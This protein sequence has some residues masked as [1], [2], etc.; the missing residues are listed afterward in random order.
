MRPNF[1]NSFSRLAATGVKSNHA[2][3]TNVTNTFD[4]AQEAEMKL[5]TLSIA[6]GAAL[7]LQ[8]LSNNA[9][10][11]ATGNIANAVP[12]TTAA[13]ARVDFSV[14]VPKFL[15][16]RV[17]STAGTIDSISFT[18]TAAQVGTNASV[19]GVGGDLGAGQVTVQAQGN[20][21][22]GAATLTYR[23]TDGAGAARAALSDGTNTMP[24]STIKVA[25]TGSITHPAAL[26][27]G[28]A[29][30]IAV[31][32]LSTGVFN[33]SA[34]W[35]YSWQDGSTVYAASTYTGRVAYSLV[36]P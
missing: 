35:T 12:G 20:S 22:G 5:K 34:N 27:D 26:A 10:A 13:T 30:A 2:F 16:L 32:T 11:E 24:W 36:Q 4:H 33:T 1:T 15:S 29:S 19:A 17:G 21:L 18:E 25:S 6:V 23:T 28:S 7:A 3:A 9:L 14:I 8:G 31:A